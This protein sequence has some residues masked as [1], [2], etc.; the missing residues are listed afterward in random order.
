MQEIMG[1]VRLQPCDKV[2]AIDTEFGEGATGKGTASAVQQKTQQW[3][4]L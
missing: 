1:R 3:P 2:F 4:G